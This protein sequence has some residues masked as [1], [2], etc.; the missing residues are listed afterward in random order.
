MAS[1]IDSTKPADGVPAVKS[2]L[3]ANLQAAKA[4][5]E[6]LQAAKAEVAHSHGL[7]EITDAGA[8]AG[9]DLVGPGDLASGALDGTP[10]DMQDQ[11][12]TRPQLKSF[13]E[14]SPTPEVSGG[15]LTL[16]LAAGNVFEVTLSGDVTSL[17]LANPP[18]AGQAGALT[19]IVRQDG[20]GGRTLA[21]PAAVRW[22][23]G[24]APAVSAAAQAI[25]IYTLI[26]RDG[27]ATWYGFVA[28]QGFA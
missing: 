19:L 8:L 13:S 17:A 1:A 15:G 22:A 2:D 4:E 14:T 10:I 3:R 6:T 9:K 16:D 7:G 28:G 23:G 11:L 12:L 27:G 20:T 18:P 24:Q 26:T 21:W 25:D 5:I